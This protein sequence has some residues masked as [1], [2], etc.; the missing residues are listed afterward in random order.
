MRTRT[1][2]LQT[3]FLTSKQFKARKGLEA[4][5]QF[6][7]GW[8]KEISTWKVT[9]KYLTVG[10]ISILSCEDRNSVFMILCVYAKNFITALNFRFITLN[11][12]VKPL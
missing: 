8:V 5:N 11:N 12:S 6:V 4:Y 10:Q 1:L 7:S 9:N 2:V 3:S